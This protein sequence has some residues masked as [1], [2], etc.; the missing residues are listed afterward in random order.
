MELVIDMMGGDNGTPA[1]KEAVRRFHLEHPEC[2]LTLVGDSKELSD[3]GEG[4]TII[5]STQVVKMESGV[6][7]VLRLKDSSMVKAINAVNANKAD[8]VVSCGSTGAFLA[9]STL[10]LK[11][12]PGVERPALVTQFPHLSTGGF[13]TILDVGAS[14]VNSPLELAQFAYMGHLYSKIVNNIASPK[15]ALL[16]NGA[17]EGKGCPEAKEAYDIIKNDKRINFIGNREA[18]SIIFGDADVIVSDGYSGNVCIKA[19]E[20][21]AKAM[22]ELMK[23]AF[24][25]NLASKIGYLMSKKGFVELKSTMNPKTVGGALLEGVNAVAVKGHGNSDAEAFY[26]AIDLAYRLAKNHIVDEIKKG[27]AN[28]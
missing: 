19:T 26:H 18:S 11:K 14:N 7:E 9:A 1:T 12:I 23:K 2:S 20:G 28:G 13:V 25:R 10:I 21:A 6:M 15:V 27:F 22:G 24:K 4:Y 17:E 5:P 16:S 3:M 8:G